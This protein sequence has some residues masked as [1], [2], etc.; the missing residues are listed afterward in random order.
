MW[1]IYTV[2]CYSSINKN[3][4]M[5][6]AATWLDLEI[7]ILCEKDREKQISYDITYMQNL[8]QRYKSTYLHNRNRATDV[9]NKIMVTKG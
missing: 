7:V 6:I 1:Y 5:Q 2:E 3:E 9:E 8:K 4:I